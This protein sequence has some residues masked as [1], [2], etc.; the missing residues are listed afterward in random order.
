MSK[1]SYDIDKIKE[2]AT[3]IKAAH[4][5][6]QKYNVAFIDGMADDLRTMNTDF[7]SK[8]ASALSKM[9]DTKFH[10]L[11]ENIEIYLHDLEQI[12]L[13]MVAADQHIKTELE[14]G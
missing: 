14:N 9:R 11:Q 8:M 2:S 4:R 3:K 5:Q 1:I 13:S 10:I 6:F 7:T 12:H